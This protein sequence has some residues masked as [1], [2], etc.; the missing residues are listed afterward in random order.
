MKKLRAAAA[1]LLVPLFLLGG[2]KAEKGPDVSTD[3]TTSEITTTEPQPKYTE[4]QLNKMIAFTFDD[5]PAKESTTK[6]L[7]VLEKYNFTATFFVIGENC[8]DSRQEQLKR[9]ITLGCE[10]GNHTWDHRTNLGNYSAEKIDSELEKTSDAVEEATGLRPKLMRPPGGSWKGLEN[11]AYPIIYWSVDTNDWRKKSNAGNYEA[12]EN[13]AEYI[14]NQVDGNPGSIVLMHDIYNFTAET[15]E[16]VVPRLAEMG[17]TICSVSDLA[18]AY[19]VE[20]KNGEV[21]F[22][23]ERDIKIEP[24]RYVVATRETPLT[25]REGPGSEK[26]VLERIPK[27]T[28][29]TVEDCENGYAKITYNGVTGWSSIKYLE[30]AE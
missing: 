20:L 5:G 4:E 23:I 9:A 19:G 17:Y 11:I 14:I 2:C 12:A 22:S 15:V 30:K 6:I 18:E 10:I 21:Y 27:G 13:L 24:G 7:D 28:I 8:V 1:L 26:P 25:L 3:E 16:I 29:V